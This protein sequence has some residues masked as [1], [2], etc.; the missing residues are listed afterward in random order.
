MT[1]QEL[2]K[3][4]GIELELIETILKE[5][6]DL[7]ND[8]ASREPSVREK[9]AAAAFMAQFY[10]G[11]ENIF[12]RISHFYNIP[13]P[14][15]ETWHLELYKRFCKPQYKSLPVLLDETLELSLAPFRKFRHIMYHGYGFQLDW[16][17]MKDGIE[18]I[19]SIFQQFKTSL[20]NYLKTLE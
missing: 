20:L 15:G 6:S 10:G 16:D 19:D 17:R 12:K 14:A 1:V 13:L 5:L 4:I 11:I 7:K 9:T 18:N 8:I 3:E 2:H